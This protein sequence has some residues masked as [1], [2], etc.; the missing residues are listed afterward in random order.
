MHELLVNA[1]LNATKVSPL[2][3]VLEYCPSHASGELLHTYCVTVE[4]ILGIQQWNP[5]SEL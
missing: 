4:P 3:R 5:T 2:N 1:A